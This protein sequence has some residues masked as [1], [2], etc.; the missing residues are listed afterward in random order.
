M[1]AH[2]GLHGSKGHAMS[3]PPDGAVTDGPFQADA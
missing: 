1:L 2:L 3:P